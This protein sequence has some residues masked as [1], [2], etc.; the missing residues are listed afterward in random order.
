[1]RESNAALA[2]AIVKKKKGTSKE[3]PNFVCDWRARDDSNVRPLPS[4][5]STLSS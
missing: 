5:G 3:V 1:M 2:N 4:E